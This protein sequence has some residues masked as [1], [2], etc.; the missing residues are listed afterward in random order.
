MKDLWV[1]GWCFCVVG[2]LLGAGAVEAA[3]GLQLVGA[4]EGVDFVGVVVA[5]ALFSRPSNSPVRE[6][7]RNL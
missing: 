2:E 4:E 1:L 6:G 5:A 3:V 7:G